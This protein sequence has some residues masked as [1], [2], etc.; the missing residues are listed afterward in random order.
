MSDGMK[1]L[2]IVRIL[3]ER[4]AKTYDVVIREIPVTILL[5]DEE[6]VTL[7]CSPTDLECLAV[8]FLYGEGLVKDG[9]DV[10][11]VFADEKRGAV[12]VYTKSRKREP[13]KRLSQRL[14]TTGCGKGFT[15]SLTPDDR[16]ALMVKSPLKV[17]ACALSALMREFQKR[18]AL[19]KLTGGVHSAAL[20]DPEDI[21]V[22]KEDIGR[23]SA[24]DKVLGECLL[25]GIRS[26]DRILLTSGRISS[27]ALAKAARGRIPV[28]VSKAAPTDLGVKLA[29]DL[30][31]TLVGFARGSRM[32][33][34]AHS[35][36]IVTG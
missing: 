1:N 15:F 8:G 22:L 27:D 36:R 30:G 3:S 12:W 26:E 17:R 6:L 18:S 34:Y 5:N 35:K 7:M 13:R 11:E 21:L 10:R 14:F 2:R 31:I 24:V 28:V 25:R 9:D 4:A 29:K 23:H 16:R 19:F 32:N 33:V 20:C